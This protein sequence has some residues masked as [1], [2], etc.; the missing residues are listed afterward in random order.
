MNILFLVDS[1]LTNV[2]KGGIER[3]TENCA[4]EMIR[5]RHRVC[6]L[7]WNAESD[8]SAEFL[9][10][11]FP[12]KNSGNSVENRL[13]FARI[14]SG[15][16]IDVVVF[17]CGAG[18]KFP[19]AQEI[20]K[21]EVP[22]VT[23][24]HAVPNSYVARYKLKY[25]GL[26]RIVLTWWKRLRQKRKYRFNYSISAS[27]VV[28][29][30]G[31]VPLL[32]EHLTDAQTA[33]RKI[34]VICNFAPVGDGSFTISKKKKELLFVGRMSFVEKR[35]DLLLRVWNL[36][37]TRFPDWQLRFVG[38]GDYLPK[39]KYMAESLALKRVSFDGFRK[40]DSF[41]REAAIFC[42]TSAYESFGIVLVEAA[43]FGC[44]PV[45]FD[46]FPAARDIISDGE[47][48]CLVPAFDVDK[49][50]EALADL[51]QND[52]KRERL[53]RNAHEQIP[54]KFS[55]R[56]IGNDWESLFKKVT[57]RKYLVR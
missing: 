23:V 33:Q 27:M 3:S 13:F 56:K 26:K 7:A 22:L 16:K 24:I 10:Y 30:K 51:M 1:A 55:P 43:T 49:Y 19:F 9:Q 12:S 36:L 8:A 31:L 54:E 17:Q 2:C 53:A 18:W 5:R 39:L 44:V 50:A 35:P 14:L 46:S 4:R 11:V 29:V 6:I 47:T 20:K 25:S 32:E 28:L 41:Y 21:L 57:G 48:G 52:E 40:P 45:A 15:L 38:D 42:M 34:D 37:Q